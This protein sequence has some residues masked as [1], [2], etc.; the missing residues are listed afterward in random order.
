MRRASSAALAS[1]RAVLRS[2]AVTSTTANLAPFF[3]VRCWMLD[4]PPCH[5]STRCHLGPGE[6]HAFLSKQV[7]K[8]A[9]QFCLVSHLAR[10]AFL[11]QAERRQR[12]HGLTD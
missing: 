7:L 6:R 1:F 5:D 11:R 4:V 8:L 12:P 3:I 2:G 10:R 9:Q